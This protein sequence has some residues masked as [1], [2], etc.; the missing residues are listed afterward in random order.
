MLYLYTLRRD[1]F[2]GYLEICGEFAVCAKFKILVILR[3]IC[4]RPWKRRVRRD[5]VYARSGT[6]ESFCVT[7]GRATFSDN[8]RSWLA[9]VARRDFRDRPRYIQRRSLVRR[10]ARGKILFYF[11]SHVRFAVY[12]G[13]RVPYAR[14]TAT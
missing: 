2:S 12:C 13:K 9:E 10:V 1:G 14:S 7:L 8:S 3:G 11:P 5:F 4:R 6:R